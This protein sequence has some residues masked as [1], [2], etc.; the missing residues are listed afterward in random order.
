MNYK[1]KEHDKK[2]K[3]C[4]TKVNMFVLKNNNGCCGN[5]Q[6][7][8]LRK[9]KDEKCCNYKKKSFIEENKRILW[10]RKPFIIIVKLS[11]KM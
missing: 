5:M 11:R 7:I 10:Q 2:V 4:E 3:K 1:M 9:I 8:C 6:Y